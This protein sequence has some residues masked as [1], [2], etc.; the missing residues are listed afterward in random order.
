MTKAVNDPVPLLQLHAVHKHFGGVRANDGVDL[1]VPTGAIV[2]LIGPNGS[3]KTTLFNAVTGSILPDSGS[4]HFDGQDITGLGPAP[5]A[6]LG[7]LRTFQHA[8]VYS[9]MSCLQCVLVSHRRSAEPLLAMWRSPGAQDRDRAHDLLALVGRAGKANQLA[10][11]LSYGQRKLLELAMALMNQPRLLLLDEPTAGVSP[12]LIPELVTRLHHAN[13]VLGITLLVIEHNMQV[14]MDLAQH[15]F[16][17]AHG[18][19]LASG[20]PGQIRSDARVL[21]AYL[22]RV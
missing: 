14:I 7:L 13:T 15:V 12:A 8:G 3:G 2:G 16:C 1:S 6:R 22:G 9:G 4:V 18:R 17:M 19:V 20:T 11:E 21:Q 10:G 5:T